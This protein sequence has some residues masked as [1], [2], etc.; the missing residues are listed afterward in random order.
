V[1]P[2]HG[3]GIAI[4][5]ETG[6]LAGNAAVEAFKKKD[7]SRDFLHR[8]YE[9]P[10]RAGLGKDLE[11]KLLLRKV[12]ENLSDDDMNHIFSALTDSDLKDVMDGRFAPVVAKIVAG[13]PQLIG[14]L[15]SLVG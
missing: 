8:N 12:M 14:V 13:R 11:K 2:I 5:M 6:I 9:A 1:D 10:W 4:A 3:G 7:F 15:K